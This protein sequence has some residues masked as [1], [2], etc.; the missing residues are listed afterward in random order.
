VTSADGFGFDV[1]SETSATIH[2]NPRVYSREAILRACYWFTDVAY[3]HIPESPEDRLVVRVEMK[4]TAPTLASPKPTPV[5]ELVAEFC[6]S[7][8]DFELRRQVES[9]TA[10]VRQ[11]I[12]AKAFSESGVLESDPPGGVADPVESARPSSL[13]QIMT[14][15]SSSVK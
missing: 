13:V 11:L 9:E 10:P 12:L 6:N 1:D 8:L 4:Q 7:L 15:A 2:L 5:R 3:I 14:P